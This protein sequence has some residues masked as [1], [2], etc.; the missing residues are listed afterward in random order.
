MV[1]SPTAEESEA[2]C[3]QLVAALEALRA[4]RPS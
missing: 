1:E 3:G 2:L 4:E